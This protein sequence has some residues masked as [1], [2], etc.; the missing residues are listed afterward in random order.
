MKKTLTIILFLLLASTA[1]G[2]MLIKQGSRKMTVKQ[3]SNKITVNSNQNTF[4]KNGLVGMWS[5][6]GPDI[7]GTTAYDRSGQG[8]NGTLTNGPKPVIGKVGQGLSFAT[9]NNYVNVGAT[10]FS[11]NAPFTISAWV[12]P[13]VV[14]NN[15]MRIFDVANAG[16][17]FWLGM[18]QTTGNKFNINLYNGT[19]TNI[20]STTVAVV[21][22]WYHVVATYNGT[23]GYIYVNGVLENSAT[24][25]YNGGGTRYMFIG[26]T[27]G[28]GSGNH[29][30]YGDDWNGK[31][32]E[33]RVYNRALTAAEITS[34][35]Q[36]GM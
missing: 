13:S 2:A 27:G 10:I 25:G 11:S 6:N 12:N 19:G 31:I 35:Y 8:N 24:D 15:N 3:G 16:D 28:T 21:N 30:A 17:G 5:F 26:G 20:N 23:V 29:G 33:V 4:L 1:S 34:L 22:R 32:D 18:D 36:I 14:N 7:S 9:L